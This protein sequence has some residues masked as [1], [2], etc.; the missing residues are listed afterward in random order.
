MRRAS[1]RQYSGVSVVTRAGGI[2]V[3][4]GAGVPWP[5]DPCHGDGKALRAVPSSRTKRIRAAIIHLLCS[6]ESGLALVHR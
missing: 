5:N 3:G 6:G 4:D 2:G 1:V